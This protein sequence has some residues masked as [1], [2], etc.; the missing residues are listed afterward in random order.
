MK[1]TKLLIVYIF[2]VAFAI[3]YFLSVNN[4][5][6]AGVPPFKNIIKTK[7]EKEN[8]PETVE[9]I[10]TFTLSAA[11][12]CTIGW[13]TN[14]SVSKRFDQ[15]FKENNNDYSYFFKN[16]VDIFKS[17]DLTYVNLEGTFTNHNVKVEKKF[18][19]KAPPSYVNILKE[20]DIE[21]VGVA[22]NHSYDYGETGYNETLK[23]LKDNNI[24]YFGY[25]NYLIKEVNGLK[26]G[27]FGLI[28]INAR[29]YTEVKK[30]ID[31]LKNN[32][33][34]IIIAAMHWGIEK[35]YNETQ[36]QINLGHYMIDNG[37]D[38]VIGTH[39]HVIQGIEKYKNK[40][41][42]Y[43]LANFSFGGNNNPTDKDTFIFQQTFTFIN[44]QLVDDNN[45][46]II[47][48]TISSTKK[49]NNYQPTPTSGADTERVI[50]KILKKSINFDYKI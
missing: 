11:G 27:F 32:D 29:K 12:D 14:F 13:D 44:D 9:E 31:F 41:I 7:T 21:V 8:K 40:Y 34:D 4:N 38:L 46:K 23:T 49:Y 2:I 25:D 15:V 36:A 45:I 37:V 26:I 35:D 33:C 39:P 30:A 5:K 1:N 10:R 3:S 17:D 20:G 24:D 43:S 47:P 16:V 18:N 42:I 22:N 6:E 48:A 19:F 28:D 50:N